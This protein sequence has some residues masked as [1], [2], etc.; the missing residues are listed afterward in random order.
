VPRLKLHVEVHDH[1]EQD[2]GDDDRAADR[3]AQSDRDGAGYQKD[4]DKRIGKEAQ[5]TYQRREARLP[6]QAVWA[7]EAQP[8]LRLRGSQSGW[9]RLEQGKQ[10]PPGHIPEAVQFV[11]GFVQMKPPIDSA[12]C[13]GPTASRKGAGRSRASLHG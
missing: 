8:P 1:A 13:L 10:I 11:V 7:M 6:G 9:S 5:K 2:Y 3:I 4:K 12:R